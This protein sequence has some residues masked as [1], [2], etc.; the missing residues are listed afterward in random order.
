MMKLKLGDICSIYSGGTPAK[1]NARYW[2]GD[3]PWFSPKDVKAFNLT[4]SIDHISKDA[5]DNSAT[6]LIPKNTIL[7]VNRSGVLAHSLPVGIVQQ[8]SSFN[9]DIKAI[10]PREGYLPEFVAMY[11]KANESKIIRHGVKK[12]PTVHSLIA[13]YIEELEIPELDIEEQ[14]VQAKRLRLQF[15]E[16][17]S[18]RKTLKNQTRDIR[19]LMDLILESTI[20]E[21][22]L[23]S[24]TK[25]KLGGV[26]EISSKLVNP[27]LPQYRDM[28]HISGENI[29][30][31]TGELR[32]VRS[33]K[34]DG[35]TSNKYHF[36]EGDVLYSKLRPYLR[37]VALPTYPGVCSADMYPLKCNRDLVDP[38][39]LKLLL[40]SNNFTQYANEKSARSRMPKL[41][42]DQLYNWE[43]NLPAKT[44][45]LLC[46]DKIE[47]AIKFCNDGTRASIAMRT[48]LEV[49]PEKILQQEFEY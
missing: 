25:V 38:R 45:Q 5:I 17:D 42:R 32:D 4:H 11:L 8:E 20:E 44:H 7:V 2:E 40:T 28:P 15:L 29:M 16:I 43:F 41:N 21:A 9:Q 1:S 18:A 6:R 27:T 12:G 48:D 49:L 26:I 3:I 30:S 33:A 34:E 19:R 31:V 23:S 14:R 37:K 47:R 35:M 13:G 39:F 10:I 36:D 46:I 24:I 22:L